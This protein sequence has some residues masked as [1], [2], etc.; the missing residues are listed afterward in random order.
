MDRVRR[1]CRRTGPPVLTSLW[2]P[3]AIMMVIADAA[4]DPGGVGVFTEIATMFI[5]KADVAHARRT[6]FRDD[7]ADAEMDEQGL[8][9]PDRRIDFTIRPVSAE[10]RLVGRKPA[11]RTA[12]ANVQYI[13][14]DS[15][16]R[17]RFGA[18]PRWFG[19]RTYDLRSSGLLLPG[20]APQWA[21]RDYAIWDRVDAATAA[22]GDPT[23]VSA[24]HILA[25]LPAGLDERW[26]E[27]LTT[28]FTER[29][30]VRLGAPVAYAVHALAAPEGGWAI[31]PHVHMIVPARRFR[32]GA[33]HGQRMPIWAGYAGS[34]ARLEGAWRATCGLAKVKDRTSA[35]F[36]A[37]DRAMTEAATFRWLARSLKAECTVS[38]D[39][40]E[41]RAAMPAA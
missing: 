26:W 16:G 27:W 38:P 2:A 32:S 9:H 22:T 39:N 33:Q 13:W 41:P 40:S 10:W 31:A 3:P 23:E 30:L 20:S 28:T 4:P 15:V 35:P 21:T 11:Y 17:D 5:T 29:N 7:D 6:L 36:M 24:W 19:E 18:M 37:D 12:R 14:R 1:A 34:Q 8:G 25:E